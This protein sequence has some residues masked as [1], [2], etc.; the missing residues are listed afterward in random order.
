MLWVAEHGRI[1]RGKSDENLSDGN[2]QL[3]AANFDSIITLLDD[4]SQSSLDPIFRYS[5]SY[6]RDLLTVQQYAGVIR[7]SSG[8]H[9]EILPKISRRGDP[10]SARELLVK[11]LVE[12]RDS[13]FKEGTV[14]DLRAH[15][16]PLFE[17]LMRQF[18]DHVGDIVRKGIARTY[19]SRRDNLVFLRGK[20]QLAEHIKR[21]ASD[22]SR[23]Y[24]EFDEYEIDRPVNRLIKGAL[25]IVN[26]LTQDATN[27]QRCREFLFWFDQVPGTTDS[28]MDFR[29]VQQDRLIQH[30]EPAMPTCRLI[31]EGLNPLT[32][33]GDRRAVSVLFPMN[34][35]FENYVSAK[36]GKI[37]RDWRMSTQVRGQALVEKHRKRKIFG[38]IPDLELRRGRERVVADTKWKLLDQNDR[39]NKYG[40]SQTDIYQ[41]FAYSRKYL[42]TQAQRRVILIYP[43]SVSFYEPLEPF[44][45]EKNKDVLYVLPYDLD[46]DELIV[47]NDFFL[48][49]AVTDST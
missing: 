22:Q 46:E 29:A 10:V 43:R 18:L 26:R 34:Q 31:L 30:Y 9:I 42:A 1:Y 13:P 35:V 3:C 28:K 49:E 25:E 19:V 39:S 5:K 40:I 2:L 4:S 16:M 45:F 33:E 32:Q 7:T 23:L 38:L 20:L 14:A 6:G 36:L 8:C 48:F 21:N 11:M 44:W 15:Y 27:Q 17:I 24:C 47:P 41:L 37:L 12:L